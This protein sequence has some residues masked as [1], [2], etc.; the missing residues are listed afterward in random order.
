MNKIQNKIRKLRKI[1]SLS[2]TCKIKT[3][4]KLEKRFMNYSSMLLI[5][6]REMY[7]N[8]LSRSIKSENIV[9]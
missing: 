5:I 7:S 8:K 1:M 9:I 6:I 3:T 2:N 4:T